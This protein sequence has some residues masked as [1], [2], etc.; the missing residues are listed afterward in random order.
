MA[1]KLV[2]DTQKLIQ[3]DK[4]HQ[5][6][7]LRNVEEILR[8][9]MIRAHAKKWADSLRFL[10]FDDSEEGVKSTTVTT[11]TSQESLPAI[12]G[13]C[14]PCQA[15]LPIP[16]GHLCSQHL[17]STHYGKTYEERLHEYANPCIHVQ[18]RSCRACQNFPLFPNEGKVTRFRIRRVYEQDS[19]MLRNCDHF[20]A[21]SYCWSGEDNESN[22]NEEP[23]KIVEEDGK[24]VRNMR[25]SRSGIDRA[26][27]FAR[28]NGFRMIW[29]DKVNF[30]K[31]HQL[32]F[33]Y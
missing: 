14:Q 4:N 22:C 21:V 28:E 17:F 5:P 27:N 30:L 1:P 12:E 31:S 3:H 16:S 9:R 7:L 11:R 24:T 2:D 19:K 15:R 13:Q 10:T 33:S 26:V 18:E 25:A 29:L 6:S 8:H 32:E 23:Y 20:V